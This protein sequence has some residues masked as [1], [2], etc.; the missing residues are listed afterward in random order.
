M[1]KRQKRT[2]TAEL[3]IIAVLTAALLAMFAMYCFLINTPVQEKR[4]SDINDFVFSVSAEIEQNH[5]GLLSPGFIGVVSEK[6]IAPQ[7][8][9][10]RNSLLNDARPFM[11]EVF[12]DV[13]TVL[14]FSSDEARKD[15]LD[16]NVYSAGEYLYISLVREIPAGAIVPA[17]SGG[18]S[19][20]SSYRPH[21]FAVKDVFVFC[22]SAGALSG[23]AVDT[24]GKVA[25]LTVR[26]RTALSFDILR[27]YEN[28]D[29]MAE[30]EF[31]DF[32]EKKY[33]VF[34]SSVART[35]LAAYN[36]SG[37]FPDVG[38]D[39]FSDILKAFGFNP[40]STRFYRAGDS[41]VTYVE[42]IGDLCIYP[43][44]N[45]EYSSVGEGVNLSELCGK[46]KEV[47]SFED[48][49]FAACGIISGLDRRYYGGDAAISLHSVLY[50]G[51]KLSFLFTYSADGA[52]IE[53]DL[54]AELVFAGNSL[55]SARV[56]AQC[57]IRLDSTYSDIPQ[58]LLLVF[59]LQNHEIGM[60]SPISFFPFYTR[61]DMDAVY[62]AKYALSYS[63]T[64]I[65][66][67]AAA[68]VAGMAAM[69]GIPAKNTA[70]EKKT[71]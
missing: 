14:E 67:N 61:G 8:A 22:D 7:T 26:D 11:T 29:G 27:S 12:S 38:S 36:N 6:K 35:N 2:M 1:D 52:E 50:D 48:K 51:E 46:Q 23:V 30:F 54:A 18:G 53:G 9:D 5:L 71:G 56:D 44:G 68:N 4:G 34:S 21:A 42:E 40:N 15:Y 57:F 37:D 64:I 62:N 65:A 45:I 70:P 16:K 47:Y 66:Q 24:D 31:V 41:S 69:F 49:A 59:A 39:T 63:K 19:A 25:Q 60:P 28:N 10:A 3:C 55:V 33:P 43:D 17:I 13:S 32:G 58:K 20:E